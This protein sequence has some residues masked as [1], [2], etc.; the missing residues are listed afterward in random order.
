MRVPPLVSKPGGS[1]SES[2]MQHFLVA[3]ETKAHLSDHV[4]FDSAL[5]D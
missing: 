2:V 3:G 4:D 5:V 1:S